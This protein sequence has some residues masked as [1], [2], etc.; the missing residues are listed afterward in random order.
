[1]TSHP[2]ELKPLS[3]KSHSGKI[4]LTVTYSY[5]DES[6]SNKVPGNSHFSVLLLDTSVPRSQK[7]SLAVQGA[8]RLSPGCSLPRHL[9]ISGL[10][11]KCSSEHF[12][13]RAYEARAPDWPLPCSRSHLCALLD[14]AQ[15][16]RPPWAS[17]FLL[18]LIYRVNVHH[19]GPLFLHLDEPSDSF[20]DADA[21]KDPERTRPHPPRTPRL[22]P[23]PPTFTNFPQ[24]RG[25]G[26]EGAANE[27]AILR[28]FFDLLAKLLKSRLIPPGQLAPGWTL[29]PK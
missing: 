24:T 15:G 18:D 25:Q 7:C 1:M 20:A 28:R 6:L 23:S 12:R 9:D 19:S 8:P 2:F 11:L 22:S 13:N 10:C 5:A 16:Q 29:A 14:W 27:A 21:K 3:P 17:H 26:D 4:S